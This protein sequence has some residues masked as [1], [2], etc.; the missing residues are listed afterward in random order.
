MSINLFTTFYF[1]LLASVRL[2][3]ISFLSYSNL[4]SFFF[5]WLQVYQF[6]W[7]S[8]VV[9]R[10]SFFLFLSPSCSVTPK[11]IIFVSFLPVVYGI[12]HREVEE[13]HMTGASC[14]STPVSSFLQV[15]TMQRISSVSCPALNLS[16][17]LLEESLWMYTDLS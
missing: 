15:C 3:V 16:S 1:Y 17:K 9:D 4:S 2:V 6:C 7:C 13:R 14:L 11:I 12:F 8:L 5:V 10:F